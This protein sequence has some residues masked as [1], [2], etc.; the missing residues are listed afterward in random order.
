MVEPV[1]VA[2]GENAPFMATFVLENGKLTAVLDS[3]STVS[4]TPENDA[5]SELQA[6]IKNLRSGID[7]LIADMKSGNE[8]LIKQAEAK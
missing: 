2:P 5:Q 6:K 7:K 4:G 3:T 1:R 8:S